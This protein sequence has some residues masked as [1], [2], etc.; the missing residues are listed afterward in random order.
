M[1]IAQPITIHITVDKTKVHKSE[2]KDIDSLDE[3][4]RKKADRC[5]S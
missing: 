5:G 2:Q 3:E 4:I 1:V